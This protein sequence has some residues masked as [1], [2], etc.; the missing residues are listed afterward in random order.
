MEISGLESLA[1][2]VEDM[3]TCI[4][5]NQD[6]GLELVES[7][8]KGAMFQTVEGAT[9]VLRDINDRGLPKAVTPGARLRRV[10]WGGERKLNRPIRRSG[11]VGKPGT[12]SIEQLGGR[13]TEQGRPGSGWERPVQAFGADIVRHVLVAWRVRAE[14]DP[15]AATR[16][17]RQGT[18]SA[19]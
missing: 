18:E 3:A 2:G 14:R 1:Y 6:F 19:G 7:G 12:Q 5:F 15:S 13:W 9:I 11:T 16:W 8:S 17:E 4:R 10:V